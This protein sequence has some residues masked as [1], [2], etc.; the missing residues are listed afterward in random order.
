MNLSWLWIS[1][2]GYE[3]AL[4]MNMSRLW[5]RSGFEYSIMTLQSSP[6]CLIFFSLFVYRPPFIY[7]QKVKHN[8]SFN[9]WAIQARSIFKK[10]KT[11][12]FLQTS[13]FRKTRKAKLW[14][15]T[16]P[17]VEYTWH[18]YFRI[19][20]TSARWAQWKGEKTHITHFI[21]AS[22]CDISILVIISQRYPS[23]Q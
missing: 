2:R 4:A 19:N 14:V 9:K 8:I 1:C 15:T 11:Y 23:R 6:I 12:R 3:T 18:V 5:I 22:V 16:L 13:K 20:I 7:L 21:F 17:F 10:Q